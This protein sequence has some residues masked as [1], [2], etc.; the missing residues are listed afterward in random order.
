MWSLYSR[1]TWFC[2]FFCIVVRVLNCVRLG[3]IIFFY[4]GSDRVGVDRVFIA[5]AFLIIL[6][7]LV[8]CGLFSLIVLEFLFC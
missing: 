5:D 4:D 1:D 6:D 8:E 7:G 2:D 3:D